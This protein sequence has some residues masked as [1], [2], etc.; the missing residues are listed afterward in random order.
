[1]V[2]IRL[3]RTGSRNASSFRI[4]VMDARASRDGKAI[5]E[6]GFYDPRRKQEKLNLDRYNY[7]LGVG[8]EASDTCEAIANRAKAGIKLGD[9]VKPVIP[10]KKAQ[11]KAEAEAKA[12]AEAEAKAK[13]EAEAAAAAAAEA[14]ETPAEA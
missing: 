4:V 3:K 2:K 1:M 5:E 12:K 11:A 10:S 9:K 6:L 8:A 14:A 13:A 7:W